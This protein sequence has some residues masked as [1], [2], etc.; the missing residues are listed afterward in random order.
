MN[1]NKKVY[2]CNNFFNIFLKFVAIYFIQETLQSAGNK[3][4]QSINIT[5]IAKFSQQKMKN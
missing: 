3:Q 4:R 2:P 5:A 1:A